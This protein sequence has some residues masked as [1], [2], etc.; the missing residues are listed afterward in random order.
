MAESVHVL[1]PTHER[2]EL[3]ERTLESLAQCTQP[4]EY[5]GAIVIENGSKAGAEAIV[6]TY[7][8][9]LQARYMYVPR[10][11]KSHAL[12]EAL[13]EIENGLTIFFDDDVRVHRGILQAYARAAADIKG[14]MFFGGPTRVDYEGEP[15]E[16]LAEYL[17][18]SATGWPEEDRPDEKTFLGFNWAAFAS[19]LKA[20]GGFN[21]TVG[22]GTLSTGQETEMQR[23]LLDWGARPTYVPDALVWHYVPE[24]RCTPSWV[25]D[26]GYRTGIGFG[27]MLWDVSTTGWTYPTWVWKGFLK[28][29]GVLCRDGIFGEKHERFGARYRFWEYLGK[30][31]GAKMEREEDLR[32][33]SVP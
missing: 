9:A 23:Q 8:D 30:M 6:G 14:K 33:D 32:A 12:N 20:C 21:P 19:D 31:R 2:P 16:W 5:D 15:P 27:Y 28:R 24:S 4:K 3:L 25:L 10:G 11:N 7:Q 13:T 1:I 22:P 17:P 29:T 26:R 18:A